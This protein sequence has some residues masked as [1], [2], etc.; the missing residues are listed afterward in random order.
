MQE[1]VAREGVVGR[2]VAPVGAPAVGLVVAAAV[3]VVEVVAVEAAVVEAE[4]QMTLV[5]RQ[6]LQ[7]L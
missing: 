1:H 5:R 7:C 6:P 4:V 3:L 2:V